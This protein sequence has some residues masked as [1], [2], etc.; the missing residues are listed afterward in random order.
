MGTFMILVIVRTGASALNDQISDPIQPMTVQPKRRFRA[1]TAPV[2]LFFLIA[3]IIV[4]R[5]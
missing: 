5:K 4:G 3:A 2:F 1:A